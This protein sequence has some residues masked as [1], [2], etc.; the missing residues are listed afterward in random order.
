MGIE[1]WL[2]KDFI[3]N[4]QTTIAL[5]FLTH[6]ISGI[7]GV[8]WKFSLHFSLPFRSTWRSELLD[9][10]YDFDCCFDSKSTSSFNFYH[11]TE[12]GWSDFC[13]TAEKVTIS[14]RLYHF[15]RNFQSATILR[16]FGRCYR[17]HFSRSTCHYNKVCM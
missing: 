17:R 2:W 4:P 6:I 16:N 13:P 1:N 5:T 12:E 7:D 3:K 14:W 8:S 9:Y 11:Q 10:C 15:P